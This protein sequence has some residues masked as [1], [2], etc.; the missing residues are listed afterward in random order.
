MEKKVGKA[1]TIGAGLAAAGTLGMGLYNMKKGKKF[2]AFKPKVSKGMSDK[3]AQAD[4]TRKAM[5]AAGTS[6]FRPRY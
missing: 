4:K 1:T 2:G 5:K 6:H 3:L